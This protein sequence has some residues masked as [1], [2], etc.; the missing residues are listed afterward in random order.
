[1]NRFTSAAV[2][3]NVVFLI[4][5]FNTSPVINCDVSK[6]DFYIYSSLFEDEDEK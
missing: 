4:Y 2:E 3:V 6:S 5:F 1:M